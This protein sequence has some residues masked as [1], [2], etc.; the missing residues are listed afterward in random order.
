MGA[1]I[2][3]F[4]PLL[5]VVVFMFVCCLSKHFL[6]MLLKGAAVSSNFIQAICLEVCLLFQRV[7]RKL[8]LCVEILKISKAVKVFLSSATQLINLI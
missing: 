2:F 3:N 8:H 7:S 4:V 6:S 1:F 5:I